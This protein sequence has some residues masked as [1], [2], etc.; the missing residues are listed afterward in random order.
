MGRRKSQAVD[1]FVILTICLD[2]EVIRD[3]NTLKKIQLQDIGLVVQKF[4]EGS[5]L[6][7]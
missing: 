3:T 4:F 1:K 7:H 6:V 5:R 2:D